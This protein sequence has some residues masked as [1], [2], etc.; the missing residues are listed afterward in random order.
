VVVEAEKVAEGETVAQEERGK[1]DHPTFS[2]W[3]GLWDRWMEG[4]KR[5]MTGEIT[6]SLRLAAATMAVAVVVFGIVI[7][8]AVID[9]T[10]GASYDKIVPVELLRGSSLQPL[11]VDLA[12]VKKGIMFSL[13]LNPDSMP[14]QI[15]IVSEDGHVIWEEQPTKKQQ[16]YFVGFSKRELRPGRLKI[17][18]VTRG[19]KDILTVEIF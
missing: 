3:S 18:F 15:R 13:L 17:I 11:T 16:E 5:F 7:P 2:W 6:I 4:I 9:R 19:R 8:T 1:A 14:E 12:E 10:S